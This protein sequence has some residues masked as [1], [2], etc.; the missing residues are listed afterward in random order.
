MNSLLVSACLA[1]LRVRYN[2]LDSLDN[3]IADLVKA[4]QAVTVCPEVLGGLAIPRESA[5]IIGGS[6]E[7]VLAGRARVVN[8][9][10]EDVSAAFVHG[11]YETL[12]IAQNIKAV[13]VV[14]K[15]SSPSC[16]SRMI[17]DGTFCGSKIAGNGVT[18]ALL[19]KNGIRV[20]GEDEWEDAVRLL[21]EIGEEEAL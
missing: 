9:A 3:R 11:A 7:D 19:R 5:E 17:Y 15:Q 14:L 18:A 20:F 10:G 8:M 6:G 12:R 1:G 13:G 16:G 21:A 4:K 2:G